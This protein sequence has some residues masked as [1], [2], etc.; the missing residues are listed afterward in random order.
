MAAAAGFRFIFLPV[1]ICSFCFAKVLRSAHLLSAGELDL[2]LGSWFKH[3]LPIDLIVAVEQYSP[4]SYPSLICSAV[5]LPEKGRPFTACRKSDVC[6][7]LLNEP[8]MVKA[9]A[10]E[11]RKSKQGL[12]GEILVNVDEPER[13]LESMGRVVPVKG[14]FIAAEAVKAMG[15]LQQIL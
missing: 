15:Q 4:M 11:G 5:C 12:V 8:V 14:N 3:R 7:I 10:A 6:R 13:F 1:F 2:Q 9:P